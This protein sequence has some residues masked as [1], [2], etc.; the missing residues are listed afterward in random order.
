[1]QIN[2]FD[3]P[4]FVVSSKAERL[5]R[6]DDQEYHVQRARQ[7]LDLGHRANGRSAAAAHMGLA[8][9]QMACA[10]S[11][12]I[13]ANPEEGFGGQWSLHAPIQNMR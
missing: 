4:V 12:A 13:A 9:L 11:G 8:A 5:V 1:M 3:G 7:E 6:T 2:A 10:R